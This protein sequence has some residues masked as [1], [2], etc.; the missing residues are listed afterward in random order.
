MLGP[1]G[2]SLEIIDLRVAAEVLRWPKTTTLAAFE[3][4]L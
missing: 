2:K 1:N 4:W 3:Q